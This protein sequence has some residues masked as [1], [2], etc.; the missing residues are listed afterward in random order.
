MNGG[1]GGRRMYES[2]I[3]MCCAVVLGCIWYLLITD[4]KRKEQRR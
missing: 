3:L 1:F 4:P 2:F